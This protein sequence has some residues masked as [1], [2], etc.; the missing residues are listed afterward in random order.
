M[1]QSSTDTSGGTVDFDAG[2]GTA[3]ISSVASSTGGFVE[4]LTSTGAFA[5]ADGFG[6]TG[7]AL[8]WA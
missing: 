6:R 5:S 1:T 8:A 7:S 4:K 2:T 3:K